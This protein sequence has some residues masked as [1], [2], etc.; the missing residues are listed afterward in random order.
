MIAG[1]F[2]SDQPLV[3]RDTRYPPRLSTDIHSASD[4]AEGPVHWQKVTD[5]RIDFRKIYGQVKNGVAFALAVLRVNKPATVA[6]TT[7]AHLGDANNAEMYLNGELIGLPEVRDGNFKTSVTLPVGNHVLLWAVPV[8]QNNT[9]QLIVRVE[10]G[11]GT[12]PG[13]IRIVPA[14]QIGEVVELKNLLSR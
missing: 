7:N 5:E 11:P 2:K 12:E 8:T 13:D 9:W 6:I 3:L 14:E 1:P 4:S 10:A